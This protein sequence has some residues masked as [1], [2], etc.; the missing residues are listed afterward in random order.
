M[1]LSVLRR[2]AG[3]VPPDFRVTLPRPPMNL[4]DLYAWYLGG[5]LRPDFREVRLCPVLFLTV[6]ACI[7]IVHHSC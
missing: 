3:Y 4:A 5:I 1:S 2:S 7:R 6:V